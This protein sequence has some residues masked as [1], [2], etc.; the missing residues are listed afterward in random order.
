MYLCHHRSDVHFLG[1]LIHEIGHF[2]TWHVHE[3]HCETWFKTTRRLMAVI[4]SYK[5]EL[6]IQDSYQYQLCATELGP[7]FCK[8]LV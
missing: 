2:F 1:T 7:N 5:H 6:S 3:D 4:Q 8:R